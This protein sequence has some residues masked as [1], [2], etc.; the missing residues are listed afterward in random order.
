MFRNIVASARQRSVFGLVLAGVAS[1]AL[2]SMVPRAAAAASD[3]AIA[4]HGEP[5]LP[6]GFAH[7][8]YADPAAPK[9][10][11][12]IFGQQGTF[13]SL[14]P[15]VVL[16]VAP[17]AVPRYVQQSLLF[18]SADEPFTAYGL[19]ASR[20]ELNPERTRL[21]FEIDPRARFSDGQPVTAAD[22]LFTYEM[23][24]TKGK[25]FHRS[26]LAKVTKAE[27]PSPGTVVFE[28]GDGSNRELPLIIGTMPI[29]AKHATD[30]EKFGETS[31]KPA[32]GSGPYRVEE[33]KPGEM[34]V[35]K[36]RKDF[37]AEEHPLTRGLFNADEIRYD[38][39]RDSNALFEAF[40]AGLYDVRLE[41]DPT[42]WMTGYDVPAVR[43]GRIVRDTLRFETPKGMT[44]L[45]FNTRRPAF[46]DIRVREALAIL[47]DFE[48]A[49]RNLF[50]GVYRRAGSFFADSELSALGVPADEREKA[51]LA[52]FPGAVR[53]DILAG[54][55]VPSATDGSGRDR[56]QARRALDLLEAAGY[57]LRDGE[58]R[59]RGDNTPFGFEI[60][61]T[62]RPQERL[63]LN[64][65][66]SLSRLGIAVSVRLIDDVQYWRRLSAFDFDMIQWTWPASAS[67][68]N[69]QVGRWHSANA[70]RKGAL[71][72][73]GVRS[74]AVDATL[75]RLLAATSRE[76][77]VASVRTLDR[78]LLSGFYA[79]PLYYL[80]ETWLARS[81]DILL[82]QR[83]PR[84][85]FS[86]ETLARVPAAPAPAN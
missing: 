10:G 11:R 41:G 37:W 31:F 2:F 7:L 18:R 51:L 83:R 35:L 29:F 61:V 25:P 27:A 46:A 40:K 22:V 26:S 65:A 77:F 23:L 56:D 82:P 72:Y 63:A 14:N 48:W 74:P 50:Y 30:P 71:N 70:G 79:V 39:Y 84:Y 85:F 4:M 60:T 58:L 16:G 15:L 19:L 81:R 1:I 62:N 76:D 69:E 44:G 43:D 21:L 73:A 55:W 13:D 53:Q 9:G 54:T 12:I 47:F 34:L 45:V 42:R 57:E 3:H 17:D 5:A 38:F 33:V 20:V 86:N 28:L 78:L 36:R 59:K 52:A 75:Q 64:Y 80:P 24:K 6:K 49:N 8:P 68:G 32:L 66:S 67:P